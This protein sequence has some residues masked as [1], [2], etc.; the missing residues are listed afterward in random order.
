MEIAYAYS[1]CEISF[2]SNCF[3]NS[4]LLFI[5]GPIVQHTPVAKQP[6]L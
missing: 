4:G 5:R 2:N 1:Y 6:A 3:E